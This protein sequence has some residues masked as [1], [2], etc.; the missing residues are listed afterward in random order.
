MYIV[1]TDLEPSLATLLKWDKVNYYLSMNASTSGNVQFADGAS[2]F[3]YIL[4][5][6]SCTS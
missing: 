2:L 3:A 4:V 1:D 5:G 6:V